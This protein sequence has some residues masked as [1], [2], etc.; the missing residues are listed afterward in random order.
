MSSKEKILKKTGEIKTPLELEEFKIEK[1]KIK[2]K[3]D[4]FLTSL[5]NAAGE[6]YIIKKDD[7]NKKL[8]EL[9]GGNLK[10]A[11]VYDYQT[12]DINPNKYKKATELEDIDV[13]IVHGD[14]A[15]AENG[16]VWINEKNNRHRAL[17]SI[18]KHLVIILPKDQIVDT[19]IEAY[20]RVNLKELKHAVF[21]SGPSKTADIEQS[22]VIG[23]HGAKALTVFLVEGL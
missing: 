17:Y 13:A 2:D 8:E 21:I 7:I 9:F 3:T 1:E 11:S 22:L 19:M 5:K 23:A 16:A 18:C 10:T 4:S 12:A 15:V 6:G 14:F 20:K